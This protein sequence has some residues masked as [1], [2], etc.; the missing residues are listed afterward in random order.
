MPRTTAP[1][2]H[3]GPLEQKEP[4]RR[5]LKEESFS[6]ELQIYRYQIPD[7]YRSPWAC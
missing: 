7:N 6:I 5:N 3:A 2:Q 1:F 4:H